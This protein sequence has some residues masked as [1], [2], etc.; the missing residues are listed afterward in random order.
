M[1]LATEK[2]N[3]NTEE[4][5]QGCGEQTPAKGL[6]PEDKHLKDDGDER[7]GCLEYRGHAGRHVLLCPEER[8][9]LGDEHQESD[10]SEAAPLCGCRPRLTSETHEA[11]KHDPGDEKAG[12][13]GEERRHLMHGNANREKGRSPE[14][15]D[16]EK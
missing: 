11:V 6:L 10:E 8:P 14:N 1:I 9:V 4:A 13:G 3:S 5:E 16:R 12:A 7:D 15:I 2:E